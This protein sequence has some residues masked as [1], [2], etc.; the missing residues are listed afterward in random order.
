[1]PRGSVG[2]LTG[3][4]KLRGDRAPA[5]SAFFR[6]TPSGMTAKLFAGRCFDS[7]AIDRSIG[8]CTP[9]SD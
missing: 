7:F 1:M 3:P 2:R 4:Q 6:T 8:R 5:Q 9:Y